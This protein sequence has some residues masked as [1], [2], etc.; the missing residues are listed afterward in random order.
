MGTREIIKAREAPMILSRSTDPTKRMSEDTFYRGNPLTHTSAI[1][2]NGTQGTFKAPDAPPWYS[3]IGDRR[4]IKSIRQSLPTP[5]TGID[6]DQIV[7]ALPTIPGVAFNP[8][9]MFRCKRLGRKAAIPVGAKESTE[10]WR[11]LIAVIAIPAS[12]ARAAGAISHE[13]IYARR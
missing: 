13:S 4:W 10:K 5:N 7:Q 12:L 11:K 6:G 1:Y 3:N 9:V 8:R 2:S